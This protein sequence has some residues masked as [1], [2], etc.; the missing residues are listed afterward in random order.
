ME[1]LVLCQASCHLGSW[2]VLLVCLTRG[3]W[4]SMTILS[5]HNEENRAQRREGLVSTPSVNHDVF[6]PG[7][8]PHCFL[9]C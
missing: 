7:H 5:L 4:N 6:G 2:K 1:G 8:L 3:V 9:F